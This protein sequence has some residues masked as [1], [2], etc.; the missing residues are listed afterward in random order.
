MGEGAE[1]ISIYNISCS[2][3]AKLSCWAGS[4]GLFGWREASENYPHK[5][6]KFQKE[7][8]DPLQTL[9]CWRSVMAFQAARPAFRKC[10]VALYY[11]LLCRCLSLPQVMGLQVYVWLAGAAFLCNQNQAA[12]HSALGSALGFQRILLMGRIKHS[13]GQR[14]NKQRLAKY[15]K[16]SPRGSS[17]IFKKCTSLISK[18]LQSIFPFIVSSLFSC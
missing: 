6:E 3:P 17:L 8:Q 1:G 7:W 18:S 4:V 12:L 5:N 9:L 14:V 16:C 10:K 15:F 2:K 13:N 11:L